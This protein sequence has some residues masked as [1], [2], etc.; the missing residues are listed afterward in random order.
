MGNEPCF[1]SLRN[2]LLVS[3]HFML[4]WTLCRF[5]DLSLEEVQEYGMECRGS[6]ALCVNH[7]SSQPCTWELC[8]KRPCVQRLNTVCGRQGISQVAS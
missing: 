4:T 6:W 8:P 3:V 7:T 5:L 2:H 1:L